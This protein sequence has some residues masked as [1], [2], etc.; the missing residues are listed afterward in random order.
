MQDNNQLIKKN[1]KKLNYLLD[2]ST[3][4]YFQKIW[5]KCGASIFKSLEELDDATYFI[6]NEVASELISGKNGMQVTQLGPFLGKI[7]NA[8]S[9]MSRDW[10][11][12]RFLVEENGE[13]KY[14]VLNKI[15][16]AD[17][18]QILLCQNHPELTLVANDRKM[19]KSAVLIL[20][21]NATGIPGMLSQLIK[22][23]PKDKRLQIIWK[24]GNMMFVK[25]HAISETKS[26]KTK[27]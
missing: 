1:K 26:E 24:T 27:K 20:G 19:L 7:L 25:K 12:N 11:E 14:V 13:I 23:H 16:S 6:C 9:S 3:I 15:S 4:L 21:N 10:K 2:T 18:A 22:L 17:Y 5:E 8:E